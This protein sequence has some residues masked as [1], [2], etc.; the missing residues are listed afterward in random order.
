MSE[1]TFPLFRTTQPP[2]P[3]PPAMAVAAANDGDGAATGAAMPDAAPV[4]PAMALPPSPFTWEDDIE[5]SHQRMADQLRQAGY[6]EHAVA[7]FLKR[8]SR[9]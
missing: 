1:R 8:V 9:C 6:D 3:P 7:M 2:T 4:P 5:A